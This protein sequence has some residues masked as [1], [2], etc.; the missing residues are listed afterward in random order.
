MDLNNKVLGEKHWKK[1]GKYNNSI[2][3][4]LKFIYSSSNMFK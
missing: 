2:Y 3:K 1:N 4:N